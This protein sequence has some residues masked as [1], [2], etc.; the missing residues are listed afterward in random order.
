M[1]NKI[2]IACKGANLVSIS[3][4]EHFQ[5]DLKTLSEKEYKKLK[6]TIETSGFSFPLFVWKDKRGC[7]KVVDGHQRLLTIQKM[8]KEGYLLPEDKLPVA[9]IEASSEEEAKKKVLLATSQYGRYTEESVYEFISEGG[10]DYPELKLE[11]DLPQINMVRL[12]AGWFGQVD[13][14]VLG[15]GEAIPN[16]EDRAGSSPWARVDVAVG[17]RCLV[18]DVEFVIKAEIYEIWLEELKLKDDIRS[19]LRSWLES[20]MR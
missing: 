9:W 5:G 13:I 19:Y 17:V 7:Y 8:I 2:R 18:G 4:L 10:L 12:D 6:K 14:P 1:A 20:A 16:K 15:D 3:K 11:I